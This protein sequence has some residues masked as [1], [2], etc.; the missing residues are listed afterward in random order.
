M[1]YAERI[2]K[3]TFAVLILGLLGTL[4]GYGLR[5]YLAHNL[6]IVEFGMIYSVLGFLYFLSTFKDLGLGQTVTKFAAE[7]R[8]KNE[9]TN[10]KSLIS[11][12][13]LIQL[14][15][16]IIIFCIL[17]TFSDF[18]AMNFFHN[19][20]A[21]ILVKI[22]SIDFLIGFT[23]F[24]AVLQGFQKMKIYALLEPVR[25]VLIFLIF[26]YIT[27]FTTLGAKEVALSYLLSAAVIDTALFIYIF[28]IYR[29]YKTEKITTNIVTRL[30]RFSATL[31][32]G[33]IASITVSSIDVIMI[34]FF[35]SLKDVALYQ[36]AMPTAYLL[37]IFSTALGISL[38]PSVSEIWNSRKK[39]MLGKG[40]SL[41]LRALFIFIIPFVIIFVTF[42]ELILNIIFGGAYTAAASLLQIFAISL[43]FY[44]MYGTMSTVLVSIGRAGTATK[45]IIVTAVISALLNVIL[46]NT[47]G[48]IGAALS[49]LISY[50]AASIMAYRSLNKYVNLKFDFK[51]LLKAFIGGTIAVAIIFI[52][53]NILIMSPV[54]EAVISLVFGIAFYAAFI[55]IFKVV[56]KSDIRILKEIDM[57][58]PSFIL[59]ILKRV[60]E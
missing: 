35:L 33:S 28:K 21:G 7:F 24:R 29:S 9:K 60:V 50:L 38:L 2:A 19:P 37:S 5:V 27:I 8:I 4:L 46:I 18:M 49:S 25:I 54:L 3:N 41:V 43:I 55:I 32:T 11:F 42:P 48:V 51:S 40:I 34:T 31:F 57:K 45:I 1:K 23:V 52:I 22:L 39:N 58:I 14:V 16:G 36:A 59:R 26:F 56:K 17:Y 20:S 13:F 15:A 53:K 10:L 47:I 30:V 44:S 12:S 6:S